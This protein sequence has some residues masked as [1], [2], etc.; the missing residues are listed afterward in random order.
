ME[1]S[2]RSLIKECRK[3]ENTFD[4]SRQE[5]K[6]EIQQFQTYLGDFQEY[7]EFKTANPYAEKDI[8][9]ERCQTPWLKERS[10]LVSDRVRDRIVLLEAQSNSFQLRNME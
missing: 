4:A 2:I 6:Q 10:P 3:M 9:F 8:D 5:Q 7:I 1:K